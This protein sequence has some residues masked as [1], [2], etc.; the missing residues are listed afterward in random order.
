MNI[1]NIKYLHDKYK[2]TRNKITHFNSFNTFEKNRIEEQERLYKILQGDFDHIIREQ[3]NLRYSI[4]TLFPGWENWI[5]AT[6]NPLR[7]VADILSLVYTKPPDRTAF[8]Y[9]SDSEN[10]N[11]KKKLEDLINRCSDFNRSLHFA[12]KLVHGPANPVIWPHIISRS[13]KN[14]FVKSERARKLNDLKIKLRVISSH[15][16]EISPAA[17]YQYD[18]I[19]Y[20][21]DLGIWSCSIFEKDEN[22]RKQYWYDVEKDD[23]IPA[24]DLAAPVFISESGYQGV[25]FWEYH[26]NIPLGSATINCAEKELFSEHVAYQK[27]FKQPIDNSPNDPEAEIPEVQAIGPNRVLAGS[28]VFEDL[29]DKDLSFEE[30]LEKKA[31]I[32]ARA[33]NVSTAVFFGEKNNYESAK[34]LQFEKLQ[35]FEQQ[36]LIWQEVEKELF[37]NI[38]NDLAIP[39]S[40]L[41]ASSKDWTIATNFREPLTVLEPSKRIEIFKEKEKL[42]ATNIYQ[43]IREENEQVNSDEKAR[44]LYKRNQE[45]RAYRVNVTRALQIPENENENDATVVE[46]IKGVVTGSEGAGG[47]NMINDKDVDEN[48]DFSNNNNE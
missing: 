24:L 33:K 1:N 7:R 20:W 38:I 40:M 44:A 31:A 42:G 9:G 30:M 17:D 27:S 32:A 8:E 19:S 37:V 18:I 2:D 43:Y 28:L 21:S 6:I 4:E 5:T 39:F 46:K 35:H 29:V 25:D 22:K 41:P 13:G 34:T 14:T 3:L 11:N 48:Y 45:L 10:S 26:N 36:L 16:T 12:E 47:E 15:L 23:V